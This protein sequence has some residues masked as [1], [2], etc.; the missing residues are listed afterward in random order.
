V[1][2]QEL[3]EVTLANGILTLA[4]DSGKRNITVTDAA[5]RAN[6]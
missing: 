4:V 6:Q 1:A 3:N 5:P 2:K